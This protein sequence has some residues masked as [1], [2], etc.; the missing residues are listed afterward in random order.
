MPIAMMTLDEMTQS[1]IRPVIID[2][3]DQIRLITKLPKNTP[4]IF[5][6]DIGI[7]KQP[8]SAVEDIGREAK[9]SST[10]HVF[11]EAEWE[12]DMPSINTTAIAHLEH[13]PLFNDTKLNFVIKPIYSTV[14]FRLNLTYKTNSKTNALRWRDDVRVNVS[15]MR[16]MNVHD[17]S[18]HY[19]I[20]YPI[21]DLI[22]HIHSLREKQAGY[23]DS[24]SNYVQRSAPGSLT[25]ITDAVGKNKRLAV[26]ETQ[27]RI[28]G[29]FDFEGQPE[30]PQRGDHEQWTIT[31]G[32]K[33]SLEVPTSIIALYPLSVH[34]QLIDYKYIESINLQ[35]NLSGINKV[36]SKS[37]FSFNEI[38]T[39]VLLQKEIDE[40]K[41]ILYPPDDYFK[42]IN[43]PF[44]AAEILTM[45][46]L[47]SP[48]DKRFLLDLNDIDP[49]EIEPSIL[50]Y[51]KEQEYSFCTKPYSSIF[52][53]SLFEDGQLIS[54]NNIS[55]N[56]K[57]ELSLT[58]DG[59]I[60]R[61][62]HVRFSIITDI[63]ILDNIVFERLKCYPEILAFW[64]SS[65]FGEAITKHDYYNELLLVIKNEEC[66][67]ELLLMKLLYIA[68]K[69]NEGYDPYTNLPYN[70]NR[71]YQSVMKTVQTSWIIAFRKENTG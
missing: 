43:W 57:L 7:S 10:E 36:G 42:P 48:N 56:Q 21:L 41:P 68:R 24:L 12:H 55:L 33:F 37:V 8:G 60:R 54:G 20:P 32:Y 64:L 38:E 58:V 2:I 46:T 59:E 18:Y 39:Q 15:N 53:F 6:G 19:L 61:C 44:K 35:P 26:K 45:L 62:Y 49:L 16:D 4:L 51:I 31:I 25:V 34:N 17:V 5:P 65:V 71:G 50:K 22:K 29:L 63:S 70:R 1:V 30:K 66:I 67:K 11:I 40:D 13:L 23:G 9:F 3:V 52:L 47:I 28:L 69:I 27:T 14:N